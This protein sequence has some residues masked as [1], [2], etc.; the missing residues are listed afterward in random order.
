MLVLQRKVNES[1][2]IGEGIVVTVTA[3]GRDNVRIGITAPS[4]VLV[5]RSELARATSTCPVCGRQMT[6]IESKTYGRHEDC[7]VGDRAGKTKAEVLQLGGNLDG[8]VHRS[9]LTERDI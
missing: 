4:D 3:I 6:S 8:S 1:I 5:L 2:H 7:W 9:N